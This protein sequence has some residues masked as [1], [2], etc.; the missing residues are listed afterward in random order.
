MNS[1]YADYKPLART[2]G[3]VI[4]ELPDEVLVYDLERDKAHCLN[5]TAALVWKYCDGKTRVA[6]IAEK[7]SKVTG[8]PADEDVI[9]LALRQLSKAQLFPDIATYARGKGNINRRDVIRRIGIGAI[10]ALP[11]I[12]SVL[13]PTAHAAIS[14]E[15]PT[16][17]GV[18]P[19]GGCEAPCICNGAPGNC[20]SI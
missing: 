1:N 12:T 6:E 13:A 2:E 11:I 7:L 19:N 8:L 20:I 14:C 15:G 5:Q 10:A 17:S 16:C 3:L 9:W 4:Q 18:G